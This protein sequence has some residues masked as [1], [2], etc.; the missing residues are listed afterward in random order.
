V[1]NCAGEP[2][3]PG[4]CNGASGGNE[5]ARDGADSS[6]GPLRTLAVGFG[7]DSIESAV[8]PIGAAPGS[9]L[10]LTF[11]FC[12]TMPSSVVGL[13]ARLGRSGFGLES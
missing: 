7:K 3:K 1:L 5:E 6:L 2:L 12:T 13:L 9:G 10:L 8:G 11:C 4:C